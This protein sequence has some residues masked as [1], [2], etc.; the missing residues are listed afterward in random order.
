MMGMI[1]IGPGEALALSV[2]IGLV[3]LAGSLPGGLV[4]LMTGNQADTQE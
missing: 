1:G 3:V 4:W 2:A